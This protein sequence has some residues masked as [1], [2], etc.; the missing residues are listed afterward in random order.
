MNELFPHFPIPEPLTLEF[1]GIFARYE[2]ALKCSGY[3]Q[4]GA[5]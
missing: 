4:G 3:A 5:A 2:Y 1:L